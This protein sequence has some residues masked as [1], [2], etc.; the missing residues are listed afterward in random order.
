MSV[1][2]DVIIPVYNDANGLHRCLSSLSDQLLAQSLFKVVIIDDGS[3]DN[4][5]AVV[6][7]FPNL[8]VQFISHDRNRG[9]PAALNTGLSNSRSR[10]F[11]R[12]DADDYVHAGF[13]I[14]M[15]WAFEN[16]PETYAVAVDYKKVDE[17]ENVLSYHK[18]IN[19]PIGCGIMFRRIILDKI[20]KY[21]EEFRL[22]EEVEFM[23]RFKKHF[24]ITHLESCLY[25]YTQKADTLTSD[26]KLYE[27][28][29]R[30]AIAAHKE[31]NHE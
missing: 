21:D 18:S 25:R 28:F 1:L 8:C 31:S 2:I 5:E 19:E 9:L 10:Y 26:E 7:G 13:L 27:Q 15:L 17:I 29:K 24:K 4:P 14:S 16:N 6:E 23:L 30:N 11:V 12:V 20:G 3:T 22:A